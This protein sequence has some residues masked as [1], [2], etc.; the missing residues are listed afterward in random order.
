MANKERLNKYLHILN[1]PIT[2]HNLMNKEKIVFL[3][4]RPSLEYVISD[5]E[6]PILL[7][8]DRIER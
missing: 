7:H 2:L 8:N 4:K 5:K 3:A 6:C 1:K